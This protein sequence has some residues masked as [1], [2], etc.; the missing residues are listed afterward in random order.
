[1]RTK[2][3]QLVHEK[4][5]ILP[6][7]TAED[8]TKLFLELEI[9]HIELEMQNSE[10]HKAQE[11]AEEAKERYFE[12]YNDAPVC[13]CTLNEEGFII[14]VNERT[15]KTMGLVRE[16]LL[17]KKMSDFVFIEDQD[18]FYL[19]QQK[20]LE[21][22]EPQTCE[23][24]IAKSDGLPV[25]MNISATASHDKRGNRIYHLVFNNID[26]RK[27]I[28]ERLKNKEKML[29][30]QSRYAAMGEMISMIAHQWRQPLNIIGLATANM[31]TKQMLHML[32]EASMD[33]NTDIITEN[34]A[35]MSDTIDDFRNF[36][37]PDAPKELVIM[38]EVITI[39]L[40]VIGQSLVANNI[41]INVHN[42]S[43]IPFLIHKNSLVQVLLNI[44]G[45][46]KDQLISKKEESAVIDITVN[47][48]EDK[49]A[50][51][52]CDNGG[53]IPNNI[54]D[55]INQPYF[56]TKKLNG[57]GLGMYISQTIIEKHFFGTL[58]WHNEA[59]GACFVI[60]L[61]KKERVG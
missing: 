54:I 61:N 24:R 39:T 41:A 28:E 9:N 43:K 37:K 4:L 51:A 6:E 1:M 7:L 3:K 19:H 35:F 36:F 42:N 46:A 57:T 23:L 59:K 20:I 40:R 32:D 60:T 34:I 45:N 30:V 52:V 2:A 49:I 47:E 38:E 8:A 50:L 26:E 11:E 22:S 27:M 29:L 5:K 16:Q 55:K 53:G 31:K 44:L 13:Y 48:T 12:L 10:L 25:W 33:E 15:I 18:I 58:T 17:G 14:E 21:L 56:T